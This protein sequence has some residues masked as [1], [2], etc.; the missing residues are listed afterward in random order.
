MSCDPCGA[1]GSRLEAHG[2]A[3]GNCPPWRPSEGGSQA[4]G[5]PGWT[6]PPPG[7]PAAGPVREPMPPVTCGQHSGSHWLVLELFTEMMVRID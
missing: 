3:T 2:R 1:L 5:R 4:L 6:S 7:Q